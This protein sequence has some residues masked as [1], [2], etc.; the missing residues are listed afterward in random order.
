MATGQVLFHRFYCK[1]SFVRF[2]VKRIAASC[3]WLASKLEENPRRARHV[4]NVFH[5]MECRR[6]NLPI[7]HLDAFSKVFNFIYFKHFLYMLML[8]TLDI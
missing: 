1:K 7:E 4:L 8:L 6:E 3:V 2:N 5:R